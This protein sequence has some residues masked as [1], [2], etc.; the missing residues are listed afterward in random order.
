MLYLDEYKDWIDKKLRL[1]GPATLETGNTEEILA[2]IMSLLV[3]LIKYN[4]L[5][6]KIC[7][8]I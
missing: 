2:E 7:S 8:L 6:V 1:D 4:F 5:L 3:F